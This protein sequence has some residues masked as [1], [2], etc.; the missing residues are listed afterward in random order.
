MLAIAAWGLAGTAC[1]ETES[2]APTEQG[3]V[4][5]A[6]ES[7][8]YADDDPETLL[9]I[10][11]NGGDRPSDQEIDPY[12]KRLDKMERFCREDRSLLADQVVAGTQILKDEKGL[13]YT[14]LEL[15]RAYTNALTGKLGRNQKCS[16][17]FATV[18][19]LTTA[20]E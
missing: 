13:E 7:P 9:A 1:G 12:A 15:A 18:V 3:E 8:A 19:A 6:P 5:T 16:E 10:I 20:E 4:E 17:V 2:A 14:N 11:D